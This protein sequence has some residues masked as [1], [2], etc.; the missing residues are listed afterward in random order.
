MEG[1]REELAG[2]LRAL[3]GRSTASFEGDD[4]VDDMWNF[5]LP[6]CDHIRGAVGLCECE[7]S[8]SPQRFKLRE[9]LRLLSVVAL[10]DSDAW[11]KLL[12]RPPRSDVGSMLRGIFVQDAGPEHA[13]DGDLAF[14]CGAEQHD[15]RSREYKAALKELVEIWRG[16]R[17]L[18]AVPDEIDVPIT[19]QVRP[20]H[21]ESGGGLANYSQNVLRVV[22]HLR[23]QTWPPMGRGNDL[24]RVTFTIAC[25]GICCSGMRFWSE[26]G[27]TLAAPA[28][29]AA[30]RRSTPLLLT[31]IF[32]GSA[33]GNGGQVMTGPRASP[34]TTPRQ[35]RLDSVSISCLPFRTWFFERA[36]SGAAVNQTTNHVSISM[37]LSEEQA[38][39]VV[40]WRWRWI[41]Y[42]FFSK[43]PQRLSCLKTL[44]LQ[45]V[46]LT[47]Q[48]VDAMREVMTSNYPEEDLLA[49]SS[50][51]RHAYDYTPMSPNETLEKNAA[52]TVARKIRGIKL[53]TDKIENG[54]VDVLVPGFGKCQ[55]RR[56]NLVQE[57]DL[58][59][60][61]L[62]TGISSLM[63][64]L[65][66]DPDDDVLCRFLELI[67]SSLVYLSIQ[68]S[69]FRTSMLERIAANCPHL[70]EIAISTPAFKIRFEVRDSRLRNQITLHPQAPASLGVS[71][72]FFCAPQSSLASSVRRLRVHI[73]TDANGTGTLPF[74]EFCIALL[75]MLRRNRTVEYLDIV[76]SDF[77]LT[78]YQ[79][80]LALLFKK[81][82]RQSLPVIR[83]A[84]PLKA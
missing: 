15:R 8:D 82:H 21:A 51:Q 33:E 26:L 31:S 77:E 67:G 36:C 58:P 41:C 65:K 52:F 83:K 22:R 68:V 59:D 23:D 70:R 80:A 18:G 57:E 11:K 79:A 73:G 81:Y 7:S 62:S 40:T 37:V 42:G 64:V 66:T 10:V 47:G 46:I 12:I 35:F 60:G 54:W 19:I 56:S 3:E 24:P 39:E 17:E 49:I 72:C 74:Q 14:F 20:T 9:A 78:Q 76:V 38:T 25:D 50:S 45:D 34:S 16:T 71:S 32:G 63:L 27:Y 75:Y 4:A 69:N 30:A 13:L 6:W 44:T 28:K 29:H 5:L 61:T 1:A 84:L 53:L 43:Y 55:I 48:D 2:E